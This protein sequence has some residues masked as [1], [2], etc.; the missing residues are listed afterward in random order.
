[1]GSRVTKGTGADLSKEGG[2]RRARKIL[3]YITGS[4][5]VLAVAGYFIANAVIRSAGERGVERLNV[6]GVGPL[7]IVKDTNIFTGSPR[8]GM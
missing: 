1:M 6:F 4:L 2:G 5:L 3:L 7:R 8:C